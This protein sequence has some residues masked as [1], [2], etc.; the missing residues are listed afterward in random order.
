LR[1]LG[2][3]AND[4]VALRYITRYFKHWFWHSTLA[5]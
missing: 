1:F 2:L 4:W 3:L 5:R